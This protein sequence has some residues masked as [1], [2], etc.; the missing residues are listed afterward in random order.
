M[1]LDISFN[2]TLSTVDDRELSEIQTLNEYDR[3]KCD[4]LHLYVLTYR[5]IYIC[6]E[7][8]FKKLRITGKL[9]NEFKFSGFHNAYLLEYWFLVYSV[10]VYLYSVC[11]RCEFWQRLPI[12]NDSIRKK[13]NSLTSVKCVSWLVYEQIGMV[14]H[15]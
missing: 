9:K 8:T 6:Y 2:W 10:Y 11:V 4:D 5:I 7:T 13:K 14:M 3:I 12:N 15:M 1:W